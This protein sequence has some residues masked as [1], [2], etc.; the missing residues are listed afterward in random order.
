MKRLITIIAALAVLALAPAAW[1]SYDYT[2]TWTDNSDNE[3]G[4]KIE[5]RTPSIPGD[6]YG[7][8]GQVGANVTTYVDT[9]QDGQERCYRVRAFNAAGDSAYTNE[10][11]GIPKP[12]DPDGLTITITIT[13]TV[14]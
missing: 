13:I 6:T 7:E 12:T 10:A 2:L 14:P 4:F 11:C 8:I 1:A 3:A 5:R 9:V